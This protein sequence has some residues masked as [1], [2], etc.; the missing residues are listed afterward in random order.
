MS[1]PYRRC[2]FI[3]D[4]GAQCDEWFPAIDDN[5]LCATHREI[6][7]PNGRLNPTQI[8]K[9]IDLVNDERT[10]CYH[11]KDGTAEGQKQTLIFEFQDDAEGSVFDKLDSHIA[12]IER[13]IEDMKA[14]LHSSRAVRAEKLDSLSEEERKCLRAIKID[15]AVKSDSPKTPSF[16]AD[17]VSHLAKTKGMSKENARALLDMDADA[18]LAKFAEAKANK[19]KG[20][21]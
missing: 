2:I 17:P 6:I 19:E 1:I 15:K 20:E 10:Y 14:R 11:F 8:P 13:V 16:K 9:Y 3:N 4:R 12:F 18:L 7:T 5:K 21:Q